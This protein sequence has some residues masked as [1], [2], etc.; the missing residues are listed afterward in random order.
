MGSQ[1]RRPACVP[2]LT[3]RHKALRLSWACRIHGVNCLQTFRH[4]SS[5]CHIVLRHFCV[6]VGPYSILGRCTSFSGP[7][8]YIKRFFL[9]SL[10]ID[11]E[12]SERRHLA[13]FRQS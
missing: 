3:A 11:V 1:S 4:Q 12:N 7:S 5:P 13:K 9:Q 6:F 10:P 8:V 2:M